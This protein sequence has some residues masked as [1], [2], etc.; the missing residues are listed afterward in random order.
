MRRPG[1]LWKTQGWTQTLEVGE[2]FDKPGQT[3][4][5]IPNVQFV[6]QDAEEGRV[7]KMAHPGACGD[8]DSAGR[9]ERNGKKG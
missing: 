2:E 9:A 8:T 1:R 3:G 4:G 7:L 5:H 6:S